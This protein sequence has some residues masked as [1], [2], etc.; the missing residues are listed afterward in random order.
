M[1]S[2]ATCF[3][4]AAA[5]A[6][7]T[8]A[9]A[10][11]PEEPLIAV[12]KSDAP[13]QK[14]AD[15]CIDLARLGTKAAVAPLAALLGDEKFAHMARYGL[16]TIPDP[17]V[18]EA[19]RAALGQLKGRLLVG[20]IQ[21]VGVRRD[22]GAAEA[23]AKL[24]GDAD[25]EVAEAAA[26]TLGK[27][28]TP[29]AVA[30]LKGALGKV[31][32]AAD[33]L[34]R[35]AEAA[36]QG[37][38]VALYDALRAA[39]LPPNVK[40]AAVRG[41]ILS[42]GAAAGLPLLLEQLRSDDP[43]LFSVA[44]K[45][46]LELP[47]AAVSGALAAE[48][49]KLPAVKQV[50]VMAV[51]GERGD[52]SAVPALLALARSGAPEARVA[53]V[54]AL[55]RLNSADAVPVLA[56]LGCADDA[57]V[58]KAA[59]AALAGFSG[60]GANAAIVG[61][62]AKPDAK[63]RLMGVEL[64]N[65]RRIAEAL[66]ALL[67]LAGEPDAP[68][69]GA[70]FKALGD[71]ADVKDLPALLASLQKTPALDA[72]ERSVSV[73]CTRLCLL[74]PGSVTVRKAVY[75]VL[76]D[77]PQ[78]DV[79]AKVAELVKAGVPTLDVSNSTFGDPAN[80]KVK[81]F[82]IAYTVNGVARSAEAAEGAEL[83]LDSGAASVPPAV[84]DP[85]LAAYGQAQ[86]APKLALLRL[87]CSFGGEKALG[88]VR[89]A[90]SDAAPELKEA[91]QRAL[92]DWPSVEVL[93]D[94]EKLA[95]AETNPKI[96][97]LALRGYAKLVPAQNVPDAQKAAALKQALGWASRD[98]ERKLIQA[99]LAELEKEAGDET[100]FR[101]M[102]NGKDLAG[103]ETKDCPWWKVVDGV[104]TAESTV[105]K[106]LAS[107]NHLIWKEGAP[108][109]F[110]LRTEFRLSKGANSGIQLRAEPVV[111]RDTGYQADMNGGGNFV[112]FLYHPKMHLVGG[113]GE[114]VTIAA[115]GKKASQRFADS[116]ELQKLYKVEDWNNMRIVCR[117][118]AITIYVNGVLMSQFEDHRPDTPRK[119]VITLQLHKG[120][121]M[122]IEY[123]NL[124]IK[125]L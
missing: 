18:D 28:G 58:A 24:L 87:L 14:K 61:L 31:P 76:P 16:E 88:V 105:E 2:L 40:M 26:M 73:L 8:T 124:R 27:I 64:V 80:G 1:K 57:E 82:R 120:P 36:P 81:R 108:G 5:L 29:P 98:E 67:R 38:A 117:G 34:L 60:A 99:T 71:L 30:A 123:R 52:A 62:L 45:A 3:M 7:A 119:G 37:E 101:P 68:L 74:T 116:A 46:G 93:P 11:S 54:G 65:R 21:S 77:G 10:Q 44:L 66:P 47:G 91:A 115:D 56:E 94:L 110:E 113:R 86:G 63:A 19:L 121:P 6:A 9:S 89:A 104:I 109:D 92:C 25:A 22:A 48:L 41:A 114:K 90:A 83:R 33:G 17:A 78:K 32:G 84:S 100:G 35:C 125:M 15:A 12:L 55:V 53:A 85:L 111:N 95:R 23:V 97:I 69:S 103:W 118:P 106:P 112:G 107:N 4:I 51:L 20:V 50:G 70:S 43:T 75:G 39:A 96:K 49:A 42:R 122:K 13:Q 72:A 59:Q 102:C 79:T